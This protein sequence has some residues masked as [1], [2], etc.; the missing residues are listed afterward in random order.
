M[1]RQVQ[2]TF[3][4]GNA[5]EIRG[6]IERIVFHNEENGYTIFRLRP[7]KKLDLETLVGTMQNPQT[8]TQIKAKGQYIVHP[9]FGRSCK[10]K[11]MSKN[12][13]LLPE[14]YALFWLQ[15]VS[16]ESVPNGRKK[17]FPGLAAIRSIF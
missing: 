17:S 13:R 7:E 8:G 11:V 14:G 5:V 2:G 16:A 15:A 4:S 12:A 6:S 1:G 3:S 10:W 9:K